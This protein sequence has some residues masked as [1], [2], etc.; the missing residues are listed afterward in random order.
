MKDVVRKVC[1]ERADDLA[2]EVRAR[3]LQVNDLPAADAIYHQSCS[4]NFYTKKQIPST[5]SFE[6]PSTFSFERATPRR[7][8]R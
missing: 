1:Q 8:N 3:I 4:S 7:D 2:E 5:F 6:Q